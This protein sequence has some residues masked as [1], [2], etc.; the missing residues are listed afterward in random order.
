MT[1]ETKAVDCPWCK[2]PLAMHLVKTVERGK[3]SCY[4]RCTACGAIGPTA[5]TETQAEEAIANLV[6]KM[7]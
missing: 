2:K 6:D 1:D 3:E 5:E 7:K 4:Y